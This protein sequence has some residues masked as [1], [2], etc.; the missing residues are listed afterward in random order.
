MVLVV[1]I[2][3]L[4]GK[5]FILHFWRLCFSLNSSSIGVKDGMKT[6]SKDDRGE[7]LLR[8]PII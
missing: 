8:F 5:N 7:S 3:S 4:L 6:A 2:I 1:L